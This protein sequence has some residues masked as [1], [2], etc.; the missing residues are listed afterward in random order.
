ML[1]YAV[2]D[3]AW[4]GRQTLAQQVESALQGGVTCVQLREKKL[5]REAFLA[6]AASLKELCRAY[7]VPFLINDDLEVALACGADG[8]HIGQRDAALAEARRL[9]G[10]DA[11]IGVS[12]QTVEQALA[13]EKGGA[14]YLGVGAMF[15]TPTKRD[16]LAV[17]RD[18]LRDICRAVSIPVTAIGGIHEENL[19]ELAGTGMDGVALVSAIFAAED[20]L[21]ACR[22]LRRLSQAAVGR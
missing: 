3:R 19:M 10:G 6:E 8:V 18:T 13:A 14:D 20:I 9:L 2:T 5:E 15:P 21:D 12:V 22:R 17:S 1:L 4:T 11:V 7:R 16:A